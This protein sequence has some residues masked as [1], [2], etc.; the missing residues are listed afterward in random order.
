MLTDG[1]GNF[2]LHYKYWNV[3]QKLWK[4]S[5]EWLKSWEGLLFLRLTFWQPVQKPSLEWSQHWGFNDSI[6]EVTQSR[7][8][9]SEE[10]VNVQIVHYRLRFVGN[11]EQPVDNWLSEISSSHR[12]LKAPLGTWGMVRAFLHTLLNTADELSD[13]REW[14]LLHGFWYVTIYWKHAL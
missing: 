9:F 8:F 11:F 12:P 2:K 13:R 4:R 5:S 1:P 14:W 6:Q 7:W 10:V 3:I